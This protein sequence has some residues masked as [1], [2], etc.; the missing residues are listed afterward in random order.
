ML[1]IAAGLTPSDRGELGIT[2]VNVEY[3]KRGQLRV[4]VM[5]RGMVWLD[6]GTHRSLQQATDFIETI[7]ERQGLKVG[8]IGEV[9]HRLG[10]IDAEQ[11]VRLARPMN[12]DYG[13]Y[14]LELVASERCVCRE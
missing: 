5:E 1:D 13:R 4:E 9:A 14:L 8:C 10:Y 7:E 2:D 11:V 6:A 12:N 3:L